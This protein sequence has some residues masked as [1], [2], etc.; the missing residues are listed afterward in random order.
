MYDGSADKRTA[1]VTENLQPRLY[2]PMTNRM[3]WTDEKLQPDDPLQYY[4]GAT[5]RGIRGRDFND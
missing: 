5:L 4:Y 3:G 2:I 1:S